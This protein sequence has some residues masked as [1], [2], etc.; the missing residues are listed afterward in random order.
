MMNKQVTTASPLNN[1]S[2]LPWYSIK[3]IACSPVLVVAPHPDDETLG[4]GGAIALLRSLNC[5][6]RVLVI[7]DG[8]LSHPRSLKYPAPALRTLR[9]SETLSALSV[10][11]V[12][13]NAVTFYRMQDGSIS[14]QYKSAVDNCRIYLTEI[15]PQIIFLPWRSD[16]HPDHRATWK[17]I[18]TALVGLHLWPRLI[19]YPIWDWDQ[20]QRQNLP[21]TLKVAAW[22]LHTGTVVELKQQAIAAY[23]SQ[24]TDLIDDDP[25]GFRLTPEM[26]ANFTRPWEVYL[27]E[28]R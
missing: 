20:K 16:P 23:R 6:V 5:D 18:D 22:R 19:E 21:E 8:T 24:I 9:E 10:L 11:G 28:T 2:V 7:S 13:A 1:P 3:D 25:E 17:L 15:A 26:L 27:E 14:A 4:C 12:E